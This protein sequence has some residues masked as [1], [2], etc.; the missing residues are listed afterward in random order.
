[1]AGSYQTITKIL[2]I[3]HE[4]AGRE[5]TLRIVKRLATETSGNASYRETIRR[6]ESEAR[7]LR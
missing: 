3:L 4:E 1:M 7:V 6:L 2:E 5:A